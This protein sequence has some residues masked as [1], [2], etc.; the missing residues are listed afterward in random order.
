M[1]CATWIRSALSRYRFIFHL[2]LS[3]HKFLRIISAHVAL[4]IC[5][6]LRLAE[7]VRPSPQPRLWIAAAR[8][9]L[10]EVERVGREH[11][12]GPDRRGDDLLAVS[13]LDERL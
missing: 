13:V 5:D 2:C 11:L 6:L 9:N 3:I 8:L 4:P 12:F 7:G 10:L 1:T